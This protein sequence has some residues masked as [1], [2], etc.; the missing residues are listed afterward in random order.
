MCHDPGMDLEAARKVLSKRPAFS[1]K[2]IVFFV[3]AG[4]ALV[5]GILLRSGQYF[6]QPAANQSAPVTVAAHP[7]EAPPATPTVE[8]TEPV[9]KNPTPASGPATAP[10]KQGDQT[11]E[12]GQLP[13]QTDEAVTLAEQPE[14]PGSGMILVSRQ[15][16]S[17]SASPSSSAPSTYGFPAGR[18]F[19][20]IGHE[21]GFAQIQDVKSGAS[22]W[23]DEAALTP[24]P[25]GSAQSEP[26]PV[27]ASRQPSK[28]S[29]DPKPKVAKKD[30]QG[31]PDTGSTT[32]PDPVQTGGRPGVFG[33]RGLFGGIFGNGN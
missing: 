31:T 7:P 19:R 1:S 32:E 28:A 15:P 21:G 8:I 3:V 13:K 33:G 16:I 25:A 26:N 10:N 22:G 29:G 9:P 27:A 14:P 2:R 12:A 24:P 5:V 23:I 11:G 4:L 20:V 18:S 30:S 6:G 17:V